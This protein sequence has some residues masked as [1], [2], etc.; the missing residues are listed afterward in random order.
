MLSTALRP[1]RHRGLLDASG[2]ETVDGAVD[3]QEIARR[4]RGFAEEVRTVR[5]HLALLSAADD[6]PV[7]VDVGESP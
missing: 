2:E 5:A 3:K 7:L 1:A 4:R 6:G